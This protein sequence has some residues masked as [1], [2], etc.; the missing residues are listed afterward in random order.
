VALAWFNSP[1]S[2][3]L[4][5]VCIVRHTASRAAA[6]GSLAPHRAPA[7]GRRARRGAVRAPASAARIALVGL[8]G[9]AVTAGGVYA[10]L[11]A[12][13]FNSTAQSVT[14]GTLKLTMADNGAGFTQSITNLAPGDV[15]N[16]YVDLSANG[17]LDGRQLT[18]GVADT[19]GSK[20][21]T[22]A[23]KGLKVTVTSCTGGTWVPA[24]GICAGVTNVVVNNAALSTL[25]AT[26]ASIVS[27][28]VTAGSALH[29]Q[30]SLTLPDQAETTA[31]GVLPNGTIQGLSAA[32]TW[33]F[34]DQQRAATTTNS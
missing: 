24:T 15:V 13:A 1:R 30:M 34:T 28:A 23:T 2:N 29:L 12:T 4:K 18:L 3:R 11:S 27:G 22:D 9:V 19:V 17:T 26:P 25:T 31:N 8:V 6:P 32:L 33:T 10:A 16:R 7:E 21:T 20:L 14:S 5:D